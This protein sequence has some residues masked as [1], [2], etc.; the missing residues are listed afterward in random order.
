MVAFSRILF[1]TL[2]GF[3]RSLGFGW[4]VSD[5]LSERWVELSDGS[6]LDITEFIGS[7]RTGADWWWC[8]SFSLSLRSLTSRP[9]RSRC[10]SAWWESSPSWRR[11]LIEAIF[12]ALP[13]YSCRLAGEAPR[14]S[15]SLKRFLI[16]LNSFKSSAVNVMKYRQGCNEQIAWC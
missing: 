12:L 16:E 13:Y 6:L 15:G 2:V 11:Y 14:K 5:I 9:K 1:H 4:I 7:G 8:S 10:S 3:L